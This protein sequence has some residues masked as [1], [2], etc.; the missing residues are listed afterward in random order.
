M[1]HYGIISFAIGVHKGYEQVR[2]AHIQIPINLAK[3]LH[4][5]GEK[6]TF[7]TICFFEVFVT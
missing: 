6:V 7:F 4:E 2:S 1:K 5:S 3:Q